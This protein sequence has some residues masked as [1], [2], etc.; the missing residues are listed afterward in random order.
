MASENITLYIKG[1]RNVEVTEQDVFLKDI[2]SMECSDKKFL[3][4]LQT[5]KILKLHGNREQRYVVSVLEII[6]CI[7][8]AY[9]EVEVQN[10]GE[11]DIIV[12]YENQK[13][14]PYLWHI[15]KVAVVATIIFFGS[16]FSIMAFNNDVGGTKLFGQIYE[17]VMG[18][19]SDGFTVL[20]VT[21]SI[22]LTFG[23][24]IF[25]NHFGKKRF[26]VDPTPMEVQMRL[27]E[28]D[29]Q[30]ALVENASRRKE[31]LEV[32]DR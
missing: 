13:T 21:Y 6:A 14:P 26:T 4:K 3:P 22:G 28:N 17:L 30:T 18:K 31:E 12:T 1:D 32:G 5:V 19:Q 2:V 7:H 27:Y 8:A 15:L 11:A 24:L 23:I 29:I 20:E 10:L 25:F 9:P 16:A